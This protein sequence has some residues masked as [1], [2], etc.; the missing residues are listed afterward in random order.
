MLRAAGVCVLSVSSLTI[1]YPALRAEGSGQKISRIWGELYRAPEQTP[2]AFETLKEK[3]K[4]KPPNASMQERLRGW[5]Q[6]AI[7]MSGVDHTPPVEGDSREWAQQY[8]PGRASRA[9]AVVHL[10]MFE[11]INA[12]YGRYDS[13]IEAPA[14]PPAASIEAA[15]AQAAHDTLHVLYSAQGPLCDEQLE[16]DM[17]DIPDGHSKREGAAFGA[18][19]AASVLARRAGDASDHAEPRVGIEFI[20]SED[21][22]MW[23]QDPISQDPLALGVHW[24][25]VTPFVIDS[26]ERFRAEVPP[27][28]SSVEYAA[29]YHEVQ[30]LGG[31]GIVTPT[32]RTPEQSFIG[33]FW[34][35]DGT[36]SLCA[37]PRLYNQILMTIVDQM[38]TD[39]VD[40]AR[41]L[42]LANVAMA[43]AAIAV[44][45]SK[46]HYQ[47][48]RPITGIRESDRGTGPTRLGDGNPLTSG[49]RSF[50]PLGA[51]ASNLNGPN[52]TPPFPSYPSGHAGFA[53]A[54]FQTLRHF[55]GT[56]DIPFTFVSDEWNGVTKDNT[57]TVRPRL[58]RTFSSLSQAE[59]EN[60]QSRIYLGIHWAF[61]KTAGIEQGRRVADYV[62]QNAFRPSERV[63]GGGRG[64]L[65]P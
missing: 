23:R 37:P 34:A 59:E 36:P 58:P 47:V 64:G 29:A 20:P 7:D 15:L 28:I 25:N 33:T 60:G 26:A 65:I 45:D 16:Q 6:M 3:T 53:G 38:G 27:D 52:F 61:D 51:P 1:A 48:W 39:F 56:D 2:S 44:W 13:Y 5:N 46:W 55:Y 12:F 50:T 40:T 17:R 63:P 11:V 10:A 54:L 8:G 42:A 49:D 41:L 22:G 43:D 14:A 9:M 35:Y 24:G 32:E 62:Y 18:L 57:G 19:I 21:P 30:R 4:G 31:D